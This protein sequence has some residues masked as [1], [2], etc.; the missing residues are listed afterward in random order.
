[1]R[2][3]HESPRVMTWPLIVLAVLTVIAGWAVGVPSDAGT[4]FARFLAPVLPAAHEGGSGG[5]GVYLLLIVSVVVVAAGVTLAWFMYLGQ[6][7]RVATIGQ[8][9]TF[10]HRMLLN[11]YW[12]DWLYDR[13]IVTP[14]YALFRFLA[15]VLDLRVIDGLV[16]GIGRAVVAW[17]A[18]FRRLQ[19]GYTVNYALT[20]LAGAVLLVGYLLTR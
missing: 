8:P 9:R 18:G 10:V 13:A 4:R 15:R 5:I 14:L 3:V 20:M 1:A 17:A 7:L 16:N 12:I 11:A 2:H 19:T 6:P